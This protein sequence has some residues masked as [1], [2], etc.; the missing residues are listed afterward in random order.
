MLVEIQNVLHKLGQRNYGGIF[1]QTCPDPIFLMPAGVYIFHTV[2][3]VDVSVT[4][5]ACD[6]VTTE[7][8]L[9]LSDQFNF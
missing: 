6:I 7:N 5:Q 1:R 8:R 9:I 2:C 3:F 4:R